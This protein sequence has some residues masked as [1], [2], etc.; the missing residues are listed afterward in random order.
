MS[1]GERRKS[2]PGD[3]EIIMEGHHEPIVEREQF[4][5]VQGKLARRRLARRRAGTGRSR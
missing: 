3:H 1:H 5:R 2:G 4:E